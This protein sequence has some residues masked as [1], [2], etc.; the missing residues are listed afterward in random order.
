MARTPIQTAV[1]AEHLAATTALAT[2]ISKRSGLKNAAVEEALRIVSEDGSGRPG[3]FW[4]RTLAG[5]TTRDQEALARW[6]HAAVELNWLRPSDIPPLLAAPGGRRA[7]VP[8]LGLLLRIERGEPI[9]TRDI[10]TN[11]RAWRKAYAL[12]KASV[13]K[14]R[15]RIKSSSQ[16]AALALRRAAVATQQIQTVLRRAESYMGFI[17]LARPQDVE[18]DPDDDPV[19]S[20]LH[21]IQTLMLGCAQRLQAIQIE[22][23]RFIGLNDLPAFC[24]S[25]ADEESLERLY[26]TWRRELAQKR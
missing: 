13:T 17:E 2:F 4:R 9:G 21:D 5:K 8:V 15:N 12:S 11:L 23:S 18:D 14:E 1:A 25:P 19:L 10:A 3:S 16:K 22:D 24:P 26:A 7:L 20:E 6:A